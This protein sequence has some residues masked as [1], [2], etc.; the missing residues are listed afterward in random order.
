MSPLALTVALALSTL[1]LTEREQLTSN[2]RLCPSNCAD[3]MPKYD[4]D[5][6]EEGRLLDEDMTRRHSGYIM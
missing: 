5:E 2:P 6:R 4:S 3:A 1:R